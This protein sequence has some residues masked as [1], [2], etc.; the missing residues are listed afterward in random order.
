MSDLGRVIRKRE[1]WGQ[2]L[3]EKHPLVYHSGG[4]F[5]A[6]VLMKIIVF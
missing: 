3:G 2:I 6:D 1:C 5:F 4:S